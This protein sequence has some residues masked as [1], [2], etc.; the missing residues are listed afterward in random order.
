MDWN[1]FFSTISQT[2]GAIVGIF[3]A[4]LITK[5]VS[6][7]SEFAK[8]KNEAT[9]HLI[10]SESAAAE[11]NLRYFKW[12]NERTREKALNEITDN[13]WETEELPSLD[14]FISEYNFSPFE[15]CEEV[16]LAMANKV[17]ELSGQLEAKK[18][19]EESQRSAAFRIGLA[20]EHQR[21][22][23]L[24]ILSSPELRANL[25]EEREAIDQLVVK[26]ERQAKR[27]HALNAELK[28]G[29]DSVN[30]VSFSIFA[31]LMLFYAGVIYPLSFLPWDQKQELSLSFSAFWDILFSLQGFMLVLISVTFSTLMIVFLIINWRL[32]HSVEVIA[33]I[34][35]YSDVANYSPYLSNY[36]K[37][38]TN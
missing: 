5:I 26:I 37:N 30:L 2:S 7:Q 20:F 35:Y 11:T 16:K 25:N 12:Y 4:F 34:T 24:S 36:I 27:N 21:T 3:A 31:V 18:Q 38:K 23:N 8:L 33:R 22:V 28:G 1:V 14:N 32:R 6:N 13:F 29:A 19:A 15:N 9:H 17:V 10:D